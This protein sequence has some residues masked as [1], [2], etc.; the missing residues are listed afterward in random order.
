MNKR[1]LWVA[2][3]AVSALG[4]ASFAIVGNG[5]GGVLDHDEL[6]AAT[7]MSLDDRSEP[8]NH[9]SYDLNTRRRRAEGHV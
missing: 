7:A 1:F 6:V 4:I 9:T 5:I 8:V 3:A 2:V